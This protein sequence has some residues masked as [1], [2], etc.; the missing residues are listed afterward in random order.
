ML[1]RIPSHAT[2]A[3]EEMDVRS[4]N[5]VGDALWRIP[6][7][8]QHVH[9]ALRGEVQFTIES[10]AIRVVA[11]PSLEV[12]AALILRANLLDDLLPE[13]IGDSTQASYCGAFSSLP[14]C[15]LAIELHS[16]K[17]AD[18]GRRHRRGTRNERIDGNHMHL[19]T[20][21]FDPNVLRLSRRGAN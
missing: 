16:R 10:I 7:E 17:H 6:D 5:A 20:Q 21:E 9:R 14:R 8:C 11:N 2:T 19:T 1:V 3:R 15:V 4:S 13:E 12:I 18:D